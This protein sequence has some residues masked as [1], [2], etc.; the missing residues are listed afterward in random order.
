[1]S[2]VETGPSTG[3]PFL[4]DPEPRSYEVVPE[5]TALQPQ[6]N[7]W[8][9]DDYG[10]DGEA[11]EPLAIPTNANVS[12]DAVQIG[13]WGQPESGKTTYL[14]ALRIAAAQHEGRLGRWSVSGLDDP[15]SQFLVA[16]ARQITR[17][18]RFPDPSVAVETLRWSFHGRLPGRLLRSRPVE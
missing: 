16:Q 4:T 13:M 6:I 18:R 15:S 11:L 3:I 12:R 8:E 5:Q 14:G 7:P 17:L 2:R 1:T 9:Q 10:L